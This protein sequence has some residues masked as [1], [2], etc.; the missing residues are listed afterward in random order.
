MTAPA[1]AGNIEPVESPVV[2]APAPVAAPVLS[3]A[4]PYVGGSL[5]YGDLSGD[6]LSGDLDGDDDDDDDDD[7]LGDALDLDDD[8]FA[9]GLHAGYNFQR[10]NIVFGPEL[11]LFSGDL[12]LGSDDLEIELDY[13]ARLALRGGIASGPNLFYG[14][15]GAAYLELDTDSAAGSDDG[16]DWGYSA[17]F[18]VERLIGTNFVIGAQYT[19]HVFDGIEFDG[20]GAGSD[21]DFDYRTLE[22]RASYKF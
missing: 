12:E 1:V 13:G 2:A 11:S 22:L 17:G 18:G 19:L 20:N 9:Y 21:G 8:G 7:A 6:G 5:G 4:G 14:T 3:F 16:N 15:L 10:G